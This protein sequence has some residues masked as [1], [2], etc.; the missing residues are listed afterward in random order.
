M[1]NLII[2]ISTTRRIV[3]H[4]GPVISDQ[5]RLPGKMDWIKAFDGRNDVVG[6]RLLSA[7]ALLGLAVDKIVKTPAVN[8][9]EAR[10]DALGRKIS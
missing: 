9:E 1:L 2:N 8:A 3:I 6:E 5:H 10:A 7:L 4:P